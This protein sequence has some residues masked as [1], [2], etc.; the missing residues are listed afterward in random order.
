MKAILEMDIETTMLRSHNLSGISDL[1]VL[2]RYVVSI[3][4]PRTLR[5][6]VFC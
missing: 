4:P 6:S 5:D 3:F 2:V 1:R